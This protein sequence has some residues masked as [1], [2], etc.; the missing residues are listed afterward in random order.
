MDILE[1]YNIMNGV[2]DVNVCEGLLVD[3]VGSVTRGQKW[4]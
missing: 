1:S 4:I 3:Q 2:Y